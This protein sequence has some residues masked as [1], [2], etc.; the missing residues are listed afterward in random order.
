MDDEF[1][2]LII[3][4]CIPI[5]LFVLWRDSTDRK[6]QKKE[7]EEQHPDTSHLYARGKIE[8]FLRDIME[9]ESLKSA[10]KRAQID[11]K[12]QKSENTEDYFDSTLPLEMDDLMNL[13]DSFDRLPF[14]ERE[15]IL[16]QI[17]KDRK[18]YRDALYEWKKEMKKNNTKLKVKSAF[19]KTDSSENRKSTKN[20]NK[21]VN[22]LDDDIPY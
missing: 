7:D 10:N 17:N 15:E 16:I 14:R 13:T 19:L 12:T 8:Q 6:Y 18:S 1:K 4:I 22:R 3:L 5:V 9:R 20:K 11:K 21:K 2:V